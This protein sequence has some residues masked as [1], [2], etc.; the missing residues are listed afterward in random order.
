M[1]LLEIGCL[2]DVLTLHVITRNN[3]E[4]M[5]M[6]EVLMGGMIVSCAVC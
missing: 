5:Y 3:D 6:Y 1:S 2:Y 4:N